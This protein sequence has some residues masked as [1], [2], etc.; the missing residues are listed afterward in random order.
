M[1]KKIVSQ[2]SFSPALVGQLGF[3][4]KRL[5]KEQATRRLGLIFV[6]LALVVQSLVVFQAPEPA[7][8]AGANDMVRGGLGTG[9]TLSIN[10]YLRPYDANERHLKDTTNYFGITRDEIKNAKL[11]YITVGN[12][13]SYGYENR[14][15]ST[16]IP[17]TNADGKKVTTLYG[18]PMTVWGWK[19]TSKAE[20]FVGQSKKAGWFA[21]LAV[22]GNIITDE[23]PP[24]P[25]QPKPANIIASKSGINVSQGNADATKVTARTNDTIKYTVSVKNTGEKDGSVT[26][27]DNLSDILRYSTLTNNGG[28]TYY[29]DTKT[30]SW[31][32]V[33]V[34]PGQTITKTYTVKLN[35]SLVTSTAICSMKNNFLDKSVTVKVGCSTPPAEI[36]SSKGAVNVTQ[37]NADATKVA[38]RT[39]DTITYTV[40]VK[41]TGGTAALVSLKDNLSEVMKFAKITNNGGGTYNAGSKTLSW[42]TVN[43][44]PAETVTKKY[45]VK[46]NDS[47]VNTTT[48]CSM[49]NNFLDKSVVIPVECTT[50]PAELEP[51]KTAVNTTQ[52]N[53]D[54]TKTTALANDNITYTVSMKNSGGTAASVVLTDD[55]SDVLALAS[56]A[57]NGGGVFDKET[58]T[59]SWG[60]VTVKPGETVTKKYTVKINNSLINETSECSIVNNFMGKEVAIDVDCETPP[61]DIV[62]SKTAIN[63]SQGGVDATTVTAH[64]NDRITFTLTAENKGG[65]AE[66]FTFEDTLSDALEYAKI[67]DNGGGTFNEET[68]ILSWPA[69]TLEPGGKE[70][71][72]FSMQIL[73]EIPATPQGISDPTSYDC[74][75]ENTFLSADVIFSVTCPTPKVIEQVVPELPK[76]GPTENMMF[77]SIVLAVVTYFYLRSR[78]LGTEVRLIRRDING[79]TI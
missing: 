53:V 15:G 5:R 60:K 38:A 51:S 3:Y 46:M 18:R 42:G 27:K 57:D 48:D 54:A 62:P 28:G 7:N 26:M 11:A 73:P 2:L 34:K 78:Q 56:L 49:K 79:G 37:G 17:I 66:E 74:R 20:V 32:A 70:V 33:T 61:S 24:K 59:L 14:A 39:K 21:I 71:R 19:P 77:A 67:I 12:R 63:T 68:K 6:A 8:A 13:K 36:I 65:T 30:L 23:Y 31:G 29:K 72:T 76:T 40:T 58:N 25:V 69:I 10:K 55:L 41:N 45:T 9:S 50:P 64:V 47:L 44:K 35:S 1:F 52:G 16:A 4:A 43:I 22:C 75:I